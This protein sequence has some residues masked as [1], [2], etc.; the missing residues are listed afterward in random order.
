M[1]AFNIQLT[2]MDRSTKHKISKETKALNDTIDQ[3]DLID[4]QAFHHKIIYSTFFSSEFLKEYSPGQVTSWDMNITLANFLKT[5]I[6]SNIFSDH[7]GVKLDIEYRGKKNYKENTN[8][9]RLSNRL[10]CSQKIMEKVKKK[11]KR[12]S[13]YAQK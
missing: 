7:N 8:V 10:H 3:L 13:K 2:P 11:K 4:I 1:E 9:W 6:I 5:E 12:K